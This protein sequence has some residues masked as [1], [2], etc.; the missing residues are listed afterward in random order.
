MVIVRPTPSLETSCAYVDVTA[1][2]HVTK[3]ARFVSHLLVTAER[4][5]QELLVELLIL[6]FVSRRVKRMRTVLVEPTVVSA[7][8]AL[9]L[10]SL[11]VR[12]QPMAM[13]VRLRL[14]VHRWV[15]SVNQIQL[16]VI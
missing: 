14:A 10:R 4:L 12:A 16:R 3:T 2:L 7:A 9:R 11:R 8:F 15:V 1:P 5:R 6:R 13:L